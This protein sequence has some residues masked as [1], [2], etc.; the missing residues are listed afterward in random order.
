MNRL[1]SAPTVRLCWHLADR[2]SFIFNNAFFGKGWTSTAS[3]VANHFG[4]DIV[5]LYQVLNRQPEKEA[6][7]E[8]IRIEENP[9]AP[10]RMGSTYLFESEADCDKPQASWSAFRQKIKLEVLIFP[11]LVAILFRAHSRWLD[12]PQANWEDAARHYW[13]GA[14]SS[15]PLAEFLALGRL[16]FVGWDRPPFGMLG[17]SPTSLRSRCHYIA[18][19]RRNGRLRPGR[20][21]PSFIERQPTSWL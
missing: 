13:R 16:Y 8:R 15:D 21:V 14:V 9:Q 12:Q 5:S 6:L 1:Q 11:P 3:F 18:A 2:N 7:W 20:L 17:Y 10:S 19:V 4:T